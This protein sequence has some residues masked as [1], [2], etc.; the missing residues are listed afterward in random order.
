M[1]LS[2]ITAVNVRVPFEYIPDQYFVTEIMMNG[3]ECNT[4]VVFYNVGETTSNCAK[5]KSR[6]E[7]GRRLSAVPNSN[8]NTCYYKLP[9]ECEDRDY[10]CVF[11]GVLAVNNT[12]GESVEICEFNQG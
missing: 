4:C 6:G 7:V 2:L 8:T 12:N 5:K 3:L 9:V 10:W 1:T 11:E